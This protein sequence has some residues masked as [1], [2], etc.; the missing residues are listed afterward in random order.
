MSSTAKRG[1][2]RVTPVDTYG[3]WPW[4]AAAMAGP[5]WVAAAAGRRWLR[6]DGRWVAGLA[7]P[8]LLS[9]QTEEWVRP[10]GFL[11]FANQQVLGSDRPDWPLT[12][13]DGFHLNVS[14]GWVSALVG[15]L[16]WRRTP[17]PAAAVLWLEVGN[18][19]LHTGL[20][21]RRRR[22]NPGV[23]TAAVLMGPH[24]VAAA[25]WMRRSG[26]LSGRTGAAAAAAGLS[27]TGLPLAMKV[28]MRRAAGALQ[29]RS[30]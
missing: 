17:A 15:L 23:V 22:Y 18:V 27:I 26:R 8:V 28:R 29:R 6:V 1:S 25:R 11:P 16:A 3:R 2:A 30:T 13:R 4:V 19:V 9:H 14:V 7:L 10:G 24:A 21:L 12:R 20:A 5:T